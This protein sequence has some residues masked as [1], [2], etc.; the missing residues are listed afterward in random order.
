LG[1]IVFSFLLFLSQFTSLKG[2]KKVGLQDHHAV[3]VL[4]VCPAFNFWSNGS[5]FI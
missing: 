2:K 5:I 1:L 3:C 4:Y